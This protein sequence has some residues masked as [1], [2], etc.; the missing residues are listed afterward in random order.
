MQTHLMEPAVIYIP[1]NSNRPVLDRIF[2]LEV[3]ARVVESVRSS[4]LD[5]Y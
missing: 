3:S 4:T 1:A 5:L 2:P